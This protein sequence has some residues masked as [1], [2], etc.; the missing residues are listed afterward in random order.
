M[1][2]VS[3]L[4]SGTRLAENIRSVLVVLGI[5][6]IYNILNMKK[7]NKHPTPQ[8][9]NAREFFSANAKRIEAVKNMLADDQKRFLQNSFICANITILKIFRRIII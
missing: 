6:K 2:I 9:F 8:M 5:Q 3:Y 4:Y 1:G 7:L